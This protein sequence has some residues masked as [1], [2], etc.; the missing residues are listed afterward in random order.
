MNR[1][2]R[3]LEI[4]AD[5]KASRRALKARAAELIERESEAAGEAAVCAQ[6]RDLVAEVSLATQ[7]NVYGFLED[8]IGEALSAVYGEGYGF[9]FER[10]V[11]RNQSEAVPLLVKGEEE[12][13]VRDAVAGGVLDVASLVMRLCLWALQDPR[14]APFFFLDEP[15]RFVSRDRQGAFGA[16]LRGLC[17]SLGIQ[18]MLISQSAEISAH[19]ETAYRVEQ[20]AGVSEARRVEC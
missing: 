5:A 11:Q 19:A 10:R 20:V 3:H 1:L 15:G 18:I 6:A 7:E 4:L 13:G 12:F 2:D 8:A 16:M 9:R 17:E 14:P